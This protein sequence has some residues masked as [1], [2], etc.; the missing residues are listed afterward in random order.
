[1]REYRLK[2]LEK[3]RA[4]SAASRRKARAE[5]REWF[6]KAKQRERQITR[7]RVKRAGRRAYI[8]P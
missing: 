6:V 7:K 8:D 3:V 2:N 1:M 5:K 4:I